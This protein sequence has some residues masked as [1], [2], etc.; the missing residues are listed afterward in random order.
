MVDEQIA[1]AVGAGPR[2]RL[3]HADL[4]ATLVLVDVPDRHALARRGDHGERI[5]D[6]H[7]VA[8][9]PRAIDDGADGRRTEHALDAHVARAG[10]LAHALAHALRQVHQALQIVA[11]DLNLHVG[12]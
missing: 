4:E 6:V 8:S 12:A 7:A 2:R 11:E 5:F 1:D 9:E 3:E 10:D